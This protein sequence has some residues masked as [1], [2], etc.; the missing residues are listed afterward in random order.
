MFKFVR[1]KA[2]TLVELLVVIAIVGLLSTI[3][4]AVTSGV[5]EQ[6]R[7]AKSLQFSKHLENVL[8]A[9]LVGRWILDE[10][11]GTVAKDSSGWNNNGALVNTPTWRCANDDSNDT[12]S[13]EGCSLNFNGSNQ[14]VN[15]GNNT[16]L[17]PKTGS[18]T[19]SV[20]IKTT[21]EQS[22]SSSA[23]IVW[24]YHPG[25]LL[26]EES[27]GRIRF[28]LYDGTRDS[29][30]LSTQSF[31]DGKWHH[32]VAI[33][34]KNTN[35]IELYVDAAPAALAV[36]DTTIDLTS[37]QNFYI[38]RYFNGQYF[39]GLIDEVVVYNTALTATQIQSQ[40]RVG[41]DGLLAKNLISKADYLKRLALN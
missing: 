41:L 15:V 12:P 30:I 23:E 24:R 28:F 19:V 21:L 38:A 33:R 31:N 3:V 37:S 1:T 32:L 8:G 27:T 20:W 16:S 36:A 7:V 13:G 2:F 11:T 6:G 9:N 18:Y 10:G 39:N 35:K 22:P 40:Y 5:S 25:W 26:R 17:D 29:S 14:Y 4:L 34:N